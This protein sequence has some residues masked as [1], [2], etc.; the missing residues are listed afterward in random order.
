MRLLVTGGFGYLGGRFAQYAA[1]IPGNEIVLG[2][3][4]DLRPPQWLRRAMVV[5]TDWDSIGA[6]ERICAGVDAI[7]HCAGMNA[8]AS[9]AEPEATLEFNGG[10]T[11]R[12]VSAAVKQRVR[13]FVYLSTAHVYG[14]PLE[15]VI[16]EKTKPVSTH[17]YA[18]SHLAGED[19]VRVADERGEITGAVIRL[20][21]AYGP[22]AH[23][24]ADCWALLMNDLCRQAVASRRMVLRS[25][26][27]QRRDF[28]P[29]S[30]ACRAM[31][32]VLGMMGRQLP[33]TV[34]LGGGWAPTVWEVACLVQERCESVLGFRPE[35]TR[36]APV[37]GETSPDLEYRIDLLRRSGFEP[38]SGRVTEID[39]LLEFCNT[40]F[41]KSGKQPE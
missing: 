28:I 12:L 3:R 32:H 31:N 22:P 36:A 13:R 4:R 20:S 39:D 26:G 15:G 38:G 41:A 19:A 24:D 33:N 10:A 37:E 17:P 27:V 35:L 7:V 30:D 8:E 18:T 34:N 23:K 9:A 40:A 1:G 21:N 6:L 25:T 2:T 16:T 5:R 29:M 11:A 14:S